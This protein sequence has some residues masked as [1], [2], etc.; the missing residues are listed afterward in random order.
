MKYQR[1]IT[2]LALTATAL[3]FSTATIAQDD[4]V[5]EEVVATGIRGSLRNAVDQK[6][7]SDK[8]VEVVIAEDIGKLPDQNLAEVLEGITGVQITRTAGVGTGVQIRGTNANRVEINGV[9]TVGSGAGRSGIDFEDVNASIISAVEVTKAPD[10]KTIEGSVGGT[11]NLK[12]IRPLQLTETLGSVRVQYEDSS[13]STESMTPRLSGAFGDNWDTD[14]GSFGFVISGSYTEQESVSFR[15]RTDRDNI[16]R[17]PGATP[18]EFLGIQFLVQ[19]QE[20]FDYET[21]NLATT[22]EFAPND[23]LTFSFDAIINEQERSQDSYRLQASGISSFINDS[24]P[25]SF[26]TVDFGIGPGMFPA[27]LT[28]SIVRNDVDDDNGNLRMSSDTGSRVTDSEI[29]ALAA[30]WQVNDRLS[31][32]GEIATTNADTANPNLSTTLNFINPNGNL[33]ARVQEAG[34]NSTRTNVGLVGAIQTLQDAI[35]SVP[36][37]DSGFIYNDNSTPFAY[38]LRGRSLAFGIDTSSPYA[39]TSAQLLDPSNYVL[40]QVQFGRNTTENAEDAFRLDFNYQLE[41]SGITSIDFG[42]RFNDSSSTFD[43]FDDNIG[44]FSQM[45]D[46]PNGA[47]FS[48][49][50]VAGPNNYGRADG[51]SLFIADFLLPDPDQ[52]FSDPQGFIDTLEAALIAHDPSPDL[53]NPSSDQNAFF[54]VEEETHAFYAQANFEQGI[55]RGNFGL[56]YLETEVTSTGFGPADAGTTRVLE[57]NKGKYDFVLPRVN[58]IVSP[59]D[60]LQIRGSYGTDIRRP[61]YNDLGGFTFDS[62]ENSAVRLGN[63]SLVPEEVDSFD[64]SVEWYFAD[65]AVVSLG[66]FTKDRTNIFGQNFEGAAILP[67]TT[68]PSGSERETDPSCPGGGIFNP[69]VIPNVLGDPTTM[70]LCVDFTQPANDA[71]TTTQSGIEFTFQYDLTEWEDTLGWASGFGMLFNYTTQDFTNDSEGEGTCTSGRG[72]N[73]LGDVCQRVGL[74]DFSEDA[75]NLTMYYEKY[76][77]SARM[78]Y[79]WRDTFRTNDFGGG[80]NTSGSS[81]FSFPVNTLDRGQLNASVSYEVPGVEGLT[82]SVEGV[83][84]TEEEIYQHCVAETGPL[85]FVGLPDR[86]VVFGAAYRF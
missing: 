13:L 49:L 70:G 42:Y 26:E 31:V 17:P 3:G 22:L 86:R 80:A 65:A 66:Y 33:V 53:L 41:D 29:F 11:V 51:R 81:T 28:G 7:N 47:L 40:D 30:D 75:Y 60:D 62:S 21:T 72:L 83:N 68:T 39:P 61:N 74:L 59:R 85:C 14:A 9:S 23:S 76:N 55:I 12:T 73:V 8:L 46:S 78:R 52:S 15:P 58:V 20:N 37:A 54:D 38:D 6:R 67:S 10:A 84:L 36:G 2:A 56:R 18:S 82:L 1:S 64:I 34:N 24:I 5:I 57:S 27:A 16:G 44:G 48:E 77:L 32:R 63:P 45:A 25:T 35:D 69:D 79:T 50:L 19:E 4:E 43:D 71:S